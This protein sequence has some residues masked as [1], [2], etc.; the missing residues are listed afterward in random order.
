VVLAALRSLSNIGALGP[1]L[2]AA[3]I[4]RYGIDA[5]VSPPWLR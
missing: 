4:D 1:D 5:D 3:A 2:S